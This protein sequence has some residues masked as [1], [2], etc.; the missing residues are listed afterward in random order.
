MHSA[1][2]LLLCSNK[3]SVVRLLFKNIF[4]TFQF[5]LR[6]KM[7]MIIRTRNK[8]A[9]CFF[10]D[11]AAFRACNILKSEHQN[12]SLNFTILIIHIIVYIQAHQRRK[13]RKQIKQ[14]IQFAVYNS[15]SHASYPLTRSCCCVINGYCIQNIKQY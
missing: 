14:N 3:Q 11:F 13:H 15:V 10:M 9:F 1:L 7:V 2:F 8:S 12:P 6:A 5:A 4:Q